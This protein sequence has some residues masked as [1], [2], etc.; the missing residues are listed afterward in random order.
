M[1]IVILI[2]WLDFEGEFYFQE[3][4]VELWL[5]LCKDSEETWVLWGVITFNC[6]YSGVWLLL[7]VIRLK[8]EYFEKWLFRKVITLK[9]DYFEKWSLQK[10]LI[11]IVITL[12]SDYSGVWLLW[13]LRGVSTSTN[14]D[15]EWTFWMVFGVKADH[16]Q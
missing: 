15:L 2:Q 4:E 11:L 5:P 8:S 10:W 12:N 1:G 14:D 9:S 13:K 16:S 6:D 7:I 3:N